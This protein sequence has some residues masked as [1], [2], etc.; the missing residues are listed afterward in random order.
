LAKIE[1]GTR[2]I[3]AVELV[4]LGE[5]LDLALD[6]FLSE[7]PAVLSRRAGLIED[8]ATDAGRGSFRLEAALVNWLRDVHQMH[9]LGV[10]DSRPILSYPEKVESETAARAPDRGFLGLPERTTRCDPSGACVA[11]SYVRWGGCSG[12]PGLGRRTV[13]A[14]GRPSG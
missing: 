8:E 12:R 9:S 14:S 13:S 6:Y 5:C 7:P 4:R 11:W 3:D 10:L 2:R 1:A